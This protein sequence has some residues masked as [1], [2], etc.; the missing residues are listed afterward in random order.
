MR[1]TSER[2]TKKTLKNSSFD[3]VITQFE[4]ISVIIHEPQEAKQAFLCNDCS[5]LILKEIMNSHDLGNEFQRLIGED[6]CVH[7][8]AKSPYGDTGIR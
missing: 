7:Y 3:A 4:T 1:L 6:C 5:Q 2:T 8:A